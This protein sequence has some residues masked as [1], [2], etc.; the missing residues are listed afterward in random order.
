MEQK[1]SELEKDLNIAYDVIKAVED[2]SNGI[3][4][5]ADRLV[6]TRHKMIDSGLF[7]W[8]EDN[9]LADLINFALE[10]AKIVGV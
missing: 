5:V 8:K 2:E 7:S 9:D 1:I 6:N 10:I 3:R 4:Q